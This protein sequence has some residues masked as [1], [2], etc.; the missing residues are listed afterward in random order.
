MTP[1]SSFRSTPVIAVLVAVSG[2]GTVQAQFVFDAPVNISFDF[3]LGP[4]SIAPADF[5]GDGFIDMFV[6]GR[7]VEG[8]AVQLMGQSGGTFGPP[9]PIAFMAHTDWVAARQLDA[10]ADLDLAIAIR[11][12][13]GLTAFLPGSGDG[14]FG[15]RVDYDV[16]RRPSHMVADDLDADGD[17]DLVLVNAD[18]ESISVLSNNG[19]AVFSAIQTIHLGQLTRGIASAFYMAA[20]DFDAD[21]DL[22]VAVALS[23]GYVAVLKNQGDGTFAKPINYPAGTPTGITAGDL[24]DDGDMDL[25]YADL[26]FGA[27]GL[28][29]LTNQGNGAFGQPLKFLSGQWVWYVTAADLDADGRLDV[30]MTDALNGTVA[31]FHNQAQSQ[32][33]FSEP[34]LIQTGGFP[35]S[36]FPVD[37]DNDCDLDVLVAT[38]GSATIGSHRVGILR[39]QTPQGRP[40]GSGQ[41]VVGG[42]AT[43]PLVVSQIRPEPAANPPRVSDLNRDGR[44]D[45][46]DAALLLRDWR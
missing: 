29:V 38:F 7:N 30:L 39:N 6:T 23:I 31:L 26:D 16:G 18:S 5:N 1:A 22:D 33:A 13:L 45:A 12:G 36:V 40:C 28:G 46:R 8:L 42:K 19:S 24:D 11:S 32:P 15:P 10:D 21:Q 2:I 17:T 25:A 9:S 35:R 4:T 3:N 41:A 44:V 43:P 14:T 37:I 20:G 27:P 34:Q